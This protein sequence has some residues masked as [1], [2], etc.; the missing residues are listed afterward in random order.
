MTEKRFNPNAT[1]QID[2]RDTEIVADEADVTSD[3]PRARPTPPPLPPSVAP[4]VPAAA[5]APPRSPFVYVAAIVGVLGMGLA[6]GAVVMRVT[7]PPP[8]ETA[9]AAPSATPAVIT[10]P[11]QEIDD[12]DAGP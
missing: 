11:V 3:E 7:R 10:I 9:S 5:P 4:P 1:I 2:L 12:S 8:A 6:I